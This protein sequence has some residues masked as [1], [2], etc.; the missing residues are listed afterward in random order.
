MLQ[1]LVTDLPDGDY[2]DVITCDSNRPQD[3]VCTGSS[4]CKSPLTVA[5]GRVTVTIEP[6]DDNAVIAIHV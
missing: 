1:E 6:D 4:E 3:G 2:C 5:Q